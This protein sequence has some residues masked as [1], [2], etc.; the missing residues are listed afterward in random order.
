M[1]EPRFGDS[2]ELPDLHGL[3]ARMTYPPPGSSPATDVARTASDA[4]LNA[5]NASV[6]PRYLCMHHK[7][8]FQIK[9]SEVA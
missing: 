8:N 4:L 6:V 1:T 7:K 9:R 5:D 3:G 2:G